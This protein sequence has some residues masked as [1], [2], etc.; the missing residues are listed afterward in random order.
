MSADCEQFGGHECLIGVAELVEGVPIDHDV[1]ECR[2]G[3][4]WWSDASGQLHKQ[5]VKPTSPPVFELAET[6]E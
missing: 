3:L 2:C 1:H 6:P 4:Q 5:A